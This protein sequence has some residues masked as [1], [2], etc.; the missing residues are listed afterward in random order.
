MVIIEIGHPCISAIEKQNC[1]KIAQEVKDVDTLVHSRATTADVL[2]ARET[3]AQWI[4]ICASY[5]DIS[6]ATKFNNKTRD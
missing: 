4:G 5:N 6:L 2:A 3:A 1:I